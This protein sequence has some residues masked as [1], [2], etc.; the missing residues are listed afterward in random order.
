MSTHQ[1]I[2]CS[3]RC[4]YFFKVLV[5]MTLCQKNYW[6]LVPLNLKPSMHAIL[7]SSFVVTYTQP[8]INRAYT[9]YRDDCILLSALHPCN[10]LKQECNLPS[11]KRINWSIDL[12]DLRILYHCS[13]LSV[14]SC[15]WIFRTCNTFNF[16]S[17]CSVQYSIECVM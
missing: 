16:M 17:H 3:F 5:F 15:P 9:P 2:I 8:W 1:C 13:T 12:L 14:F 4:Q 6:L 10:N 7:L 11:P